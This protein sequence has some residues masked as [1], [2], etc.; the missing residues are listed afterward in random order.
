MSE[1]RREARVEG[2]APSE[3]LKAGRVEVDAPGGFEPPSRRPERRVLPLDDGAERIHELAPAMGLA[4]TF[5]ALTRQCLVFF[6]F[7]ENGSLTR[8][9]RQQPNTPALRARLTVGTRKSHARYGMSR[10]MWLHR[11]H[12]GTTLARTCPFRLSIRSKVIMS[13]VSPQY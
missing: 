13:S 5:P 10:L 2:L 8:A 12:A 7:A 9:L 4:P 6:D 3:A 11:M 1:R